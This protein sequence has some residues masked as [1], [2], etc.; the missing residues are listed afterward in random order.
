MSRLRE[1]YVKEVAPGLKKEFGYKNVMAIPKLEK[2]VINMGLGEAVSNPK[3]LDSA[4]EELGA[5]TG[6]RPV[7]T[8]A[9][10][11][12]AVFKLRGGQKIG[13][14]VPS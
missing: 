9:K 6:Q 4:V 7:V 10:K 12:I 5:I 8:K 14:M 11:S 1:H 3:I 13:A 2:V